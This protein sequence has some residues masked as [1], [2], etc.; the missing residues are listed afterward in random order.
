MK[1]KLTP[2]FTEADLQREIDQFLN[3]VIRIIKLEL[4]HIALQIVNDARL[5]SK[6]EG[7]FDDQT[8]N[9]RN[10]MGYILMCDGEI[11]HE[12][13][14]ATAAGT[15]GSE[16]IEKGKNEAQKIAAEA[17]QGWAVILVAGMEYASWVEA[18]GYSVLTASTLG[19]EA[20]LQKALNNV[21]K[22]FK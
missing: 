18:K 9:L 1:L 11:I 4:D 19:I 20:K 14:S 17:H 21:L 12:E 22:A 2:M 13:F 10:S 6:S 8:G 5:R 16:G 7:G 15:D 3:D